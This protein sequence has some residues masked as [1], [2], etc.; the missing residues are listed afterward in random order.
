MRF[1]YKKM[2]LMYALIPMLTVAFIMFTVSNTSSRKEV[3]RLS[4]QSMRSLISG[5]G[6][7]VD[8]QIESCESILKAFSIAPVVEDALR[9]PED[10]AKL[11]LAQQYTLEYFG[12]LEGWEGLYVATWGSKV[13]THPT[14]PPV[15]G[16]VLR[17][18]D[19]LKSL[20]DS[21]VSADNGVYNAGIIVSPATGDLTISMYVPVLDDNGKPLG[22]VGAGAFM[23]PI[24]SK[25]DDVTR[26]DLPSAYF[27][28]IDKDGVIIYHKDPEKMGTSVE[29]KVIL[30]LVSDVKS[31]KTDDIGV[32]THINNGED[33]RAAYYVGEDSAYII[34]IEA[35]E[36]DIMRGVEEMNR[37]NLIVMAITCVIF[38]IIAILFQIII[39]KPLHDI[40]KELGRIAEGDLT[41][42][43]KIKSTLFEC[44]EIIKGVGKL[45]EVL[46]GVGSNLNDGTGTL[47]DSMGVVTSSVNTCADASEAITSTVEGISSGSMMMAESVT[48][49]S[50]EISKMGD[51]INETNS[52]ATNTKVRADSMSKISMESH[53]LLKDLIEA[54]E[55]TTGSAKEVIESVGE[56][57]RAI[58]LITEA[59]ASITAI[60]AQTNLLSL[61]ASIEAARA[62]DAGRGFAVVAAEI[63]KLAQSS[64]ES[65]AEIQRIIKDITVIS[66][67]SGESA[68]KI[69]ESVEH[70]K[71]ALESVH[72]VFTEVIE[73]MKQM[74]SE[75][76]VIANKIE[77]VDGEKDTILHEV[78]SLSAIAEENA[79]S[80]QEA[81][82]TIEEMTANIENIKNQVEK[83]NDV[84]SGLG[85]T[86]SRFKLK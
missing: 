47:N 83:V 6:D 82:A 72:S 45:K 32:I 7:G 42:T 29:D 28:A 84:A 79:A 58:G 12:T 23:G 81:N 78:E 34:L 31:N 5:I 71:G 76:A 69:G 35:E 70:E 66:K 51:Q 26:L 30:D 9:N 75:V 56:T 37:E 10:S 11:E 49:I 57:N 15:I 4:S 38:F 1:D 39:V 59:A 67:K 50:K 55:S 46:T 41:S 43:A 77:V 22:Y 14:A 61:N 48:T 33:W 24:V 8:N 21:M 19:S 53:K 40:V 74:T 25:Y 17:E 16:K 63:G 54:N 80:T 36:V 44:K 68:T 62:G 13:L 2:L 65:S 73:G 64:G 20:Q 86:A 52:I 85:E 18:G 3:Q 60:A 27:Y